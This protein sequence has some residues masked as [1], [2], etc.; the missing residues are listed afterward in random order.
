MTQPR[1]AHR[2]AFLMAG[3]R[4]CHL[5]SEAS[6]SIPAQWMRFNGSPELLHRVGT[7]SFGG[8][9]QAN[10]T[11]FEYMCAHEVS[12]YDGL[13]ASVGRMKVPDQQYAVFT[14]QGHI[15]SIKDSWQT[16]MN[17]IPNAQWVDGETPSFELYD[18][19]YDPSTGTGIVELWI[20]I[21]PVA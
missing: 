20:P 7:H 19:R 1:L 21:K 8:I 13:P 5:H 15:S 16:A 2:P 14:H 3:S 11:G 9:C 10:E 18:E 17:W 12:S 4:Q 6:S